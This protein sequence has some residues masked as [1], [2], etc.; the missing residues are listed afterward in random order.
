[1]QMDQFSN[2]FVDELIKNIL[3]ED[4]GYDSD[5]FSFLTSQKDLDGEK[6][7]KLEKS[8]I[9]F[10]LPNKNEINASG[11]ESSDYQLP[12]LTIYSFVMT[13]LGLCNRGA[14]RSKKIPLTKA[15]TREINRYKSIIST[16]LNDF[17]KNE[18]VELFYDNMQHSLNVENKKLGINIA[19][20]FETLKTWGA[21]ND[22]NK[23]L[24]VIAGFVRG[25]YGSDSKETDRKTLNSINQGI[26]NY[27]ERNDGEEASSAKRMKMQTGG[28]ENEYTPSDME[29]Q[30]VKKI[31]SQI[32]PII[33]EGE[34][35]G[36]SPKAYIK[37]L[38]NADS[39]KSILREPVMDGIRN[40]IMA[41]KGTCGEY[42]NFIVKYLES[43]EKG[44]EKVHA[45]TVI[46]TD[47]KNKLTQ[48]AKEMKENGMKDG[49]TFSNL[50]N[51]IAENNRMASDFLKKT[52][53]V[54]AKGAAEKFSSFEEFNKAMY[55]PDVMKGIYESLSVNVRARAKGEARKGRA[56]E[57]DARSIR[58]QIAN[59]ERKAEAQK[60][61]SG[62]IDPKLAEQINNLKQK[63]K[64]IIDDIK[65]KRAENGEDDSDLRSLENS[66]KGIE[67]HEEEIEYMTWAFDVYSKNSETL[68]FVAKKLYEILS[69]FNK[70]INI[71]AIDSANS[72][73]ATTFIIDY[74]KS[75]KIYKAFKDKPEL[76]DQITAWVSQEIKKGLGKN[77]KFDT[78]EGLINL[79]QE[80][81]F[82]KLDSGE[83]AEDAWADF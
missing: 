59:L 10:R 15:N 18:P 3:K 61:N 12:A 68:N 73:K 66:Q 29:V 57:V 30:M 42:A 62:K 26:N 1:M 47:V 22:R 64:Q 14:V 2:Y 44:S 51:Y 65:N 37:M 63:A 75:S 19:S 80:E 32:Q 39:F 34:A 28:T 33:K 54:D 7:K 8:K 25:K 35:S 79:T 77:I 60:E 52:L 23:L 53:G 56:L 6:T 4:V 78:E 49:M 5:N 81:S 9:I 38:T 83:S 46:D 40:D 13:Q 50:M 55:A 58:K 36:K 17:G 11:I 21:L 69:N 43:Q 20:V 74:P 71:D 76:T 27:A 72:D 70:H 45:K 24:Q 41:F 82:S 48:I 31:Y 16:V 67:K